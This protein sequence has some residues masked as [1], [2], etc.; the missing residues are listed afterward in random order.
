MSPSKRKPWAISARHSHMKRRRRQSTF[1]SSFQRF[2][3]TT[4]S[5]P[6]PLSSS[7]RR[8]SSRASS[9]T[10]FC[11]PP[12]VSS[13]IM[14]STRMFDALRFVL[15]S[16]LPARAPHLE[17]DEEPELLHV[18]A[19]ARRAPVAEIGDGARDR[20]RVEEATRADAL[21]REVFVD[22]RRELAAQ[23]AR[24]RDREA[25]LG[26]LEQLARHVLVEH[27]AQQVLGA[28]R[29]AAHLERQAEGELHQAVV[30]H[31]LAAL[32]AAG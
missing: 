10:C 8:T 20:I 9:I 32:E 13:L 26:P 4:S 7:P 16:A 17:G 19:I 31:R 15:R 5:T 3:S 25:L 18:E 1:G 28:E 11:A 12:K 6:E 22:Q 27:L 30:E 2:W 29:S 14:N 24:E 23:P 21:R